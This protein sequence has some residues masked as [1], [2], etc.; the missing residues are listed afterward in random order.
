VAPWGSDEAFLNANCVLDYFAVP[1]L[2]GLLPQCPFCNH[3]NPAGAKYCN[4]CGSPLHLKPCNQCETINDRVA[5]NCY[6][7]GTAFPVLSTTPEAAS[8]S[9]ALS[10]TAASATLSDTGFERGRAPPLEPL[11]ES[12]DIPLRR[13]DNETVG[14]ARDYTI[15]VVARE[16]RSFDG[17]VA[18][19]FSAA[20]QVAP[21]HELGA[22]ARRR[23]L[24]RLALAVVLPAILLTAVGVSAYYVY[25]HQV[26]PSGSLRAG[27]TDPAAPTGVTASP[28]NQSGKGVIGTDGVN[29]QALTPRQPDTAVTPPPEVSTSDQAAPAQQLV[30][31]T[32]EVGRATDAKTTVAAQPRHKTTRVAASR[33][34]SARSATDPSAST[35]RAAAAGAAVQLPQSN[36]RVN[37]PSDAPRPSTCTEAVAALGL[38]SVTPRSESR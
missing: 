24:P 26:Q 23:P 38:C 5:S 4:K 11:A 31:E 22:A 19:L 13:P 37:V 14:E 6:S 15:E 29:G 1:V 28:V 17:G 21:S 30:T 18:S 32:A 25:R 36:S 10:T 20:Q 7:C 27:P 8:V 33:V 2:S 35:Y 12:H 34:A 3:A 16:P 9:P